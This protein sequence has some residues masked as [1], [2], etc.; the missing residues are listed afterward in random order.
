MV[1]NMPK[2]NVS[3]YGYVYESKLRPLPRS[4]LSE[5]KGSH[6]NYK[7]IKEERKIKTVEPLRKNLFKNYELS[8]VEAPPPDIGLDWLSEELNMEKED[9]IKT[10][11]DEKENHNEL[12]DTIGNIFEKNDMLHKYKI[13][14][15]VEKIV[16]QSQ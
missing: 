12:H 14:D 7:V 2:E 10:I 16:Q 4:L 5:L 9:V 11:N 3:E 1:N 8:L 6:D 13:D 15:F